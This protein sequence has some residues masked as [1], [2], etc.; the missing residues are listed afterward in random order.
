MKD[1]DPSGINRGIC[2]KEPEERGEVLV[3][4]SSIFIEMDAGVIEFIGGDRYIL[5]EAIIK[6]DDILY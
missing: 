4:I 5:D 1:E 6:K 3:I 2:A